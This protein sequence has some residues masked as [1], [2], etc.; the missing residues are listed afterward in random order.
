MANSKTLD[1][2]P[3]YLKTSANKR[4]LGATLDQ[5]MSEPRLKKFNG[6]IGRQFSPV[7]RRDDKYVIENTS[8]RQNYQLEPSIVISDDRGMAEFYANYTDILQQINFNGG[9]TN[10]H[11]RLFANQ[12]YSYNGHFDLDKLVNFTQYYWLP[13][14]P[15]VVEVGL[16]YVPLEKD[17][18]V[19]V[20]NKNN[21]YLFDTDPNKNPEIIL[22]RGGSYSFAVGHSGSKFYIQTELGSG[23]SVNNPNISTREIF[24]VVNNGVNTGTVV[25]N[26]PLSSDQ[27]SFKNMPVGFNADLATTLSYN[28]LANRLLSDVLGDYESIDGYVGDLNNKYIIFLDPENTGG[29]W[30]SI[31]ALDENDNPLP[32]YPSQTISLTNRANVFQIKLIELTT[33][34]LVTLINV[35]NTITDTRIFVNNGE[36]YGGLQWYRSGNSLVEYPIITAD[37]DILFYQN[38]SNPNL[39]GRIRL[40]DLETTVIDIESEILGKTE[41]TSPNGIKF[42]NGLKIGF[43]NSVTPSSYA[44]NEYYIEG[45]GK[46][47]R[48]IK[49]EDLIADW[50]SSTAY[51][52]DDLFLYDKIAYKVTTDF[53]SGTTFDE[54]GTS[55]G[56]NYEF[57]DNI[58][59]ITINR[60]SR[61]K[62]LWSRTNRWFHQRTI[63]S[64][65]NY[66]KV[67]M[68][69]NQSYR[70]KRPIIEFE[71]DLQ[72]FNF[73]R[74][75]I[76]QVDFYDN[77]YTDAFGTETIITFAGSTD[78]TTNPLTT[79]VFQDVTLTSGMKII[80]GADTD[81]DVKKTIYEI[82]IVE[83]DGNDTIILTPYAVV[84]E[85]QNV[86]VTNGFYANKYYHYQNNQWFQSQIKSTIQQKP[87]FD[88]FDIEGLSLSEWQFSN[89]V[90]TSLFSYKVGTGTDD[91]V[92]GFPLSYR[93]LGNVGDIE[94]TNNFEVDRFNY[95]IDNLLTTSDVSVGFLGKNISR[96]EQQKINVWS[97]SVDKTQQYQLFSEIGDGIKDS[98]TYNLIV[99]TSGVNTPVKVY[100]DNELENF[101]NIVITIADNKT[102]IVLDRVPEADS[103]IDIL[104][105][106]DQTDNSG[107]YQIPSNLENNALNDDFSELTLGQIRSHVKEVFSSLQD[108]VGVE[109]GN[110][111]SKDLD[112]SQISGTILQHSSPMIYG[113]LFLTHQKAN[114]IQGVQYAQKEYNKFKNR[115]LER[116]KSVNFY[117]Q[118]K[119]AE[120]VDEILKQLVLARATDSPWYYS[121]MVPYGDNRTTYS[122]T[123]LDVDIEY[124]QIESI[125]SESAASNRAVLVYLNSE[126]LIK[127]KDY[128]VSQTLPAIKLLPE[129]SRSLN[130]II[131]IV[132]YTNTDGNFVPETPT[133]L[134]LYPKFEP[135]IYL[136]DRFSEPISVI[137]GHDGSITPAFNDYRDLFLLELEK[138]IFNNLKTQYDIENRS[139]MW[140]ILPGKFR[141]S[142]FT[143]NEFDLIISSNFLKW[144]G[145]NQLD[146]ITNQFYDSNNSKTWNFKKSTSVLDNEVLPGNWR[147]IY[148][149]FYDTD[150]PHSHPWEMLGF[151]EKP[152]WWDEEYGAAPYTKGNSIL[153][154]DLE[155]GY[156]RQGTRIGIDSRFSRPGLS[157][158]IPVD[159][160][161]DLKTPDTF[162]IKNFNG[163]NTASSWAVGD[164]GPVESA[165]RMSSDYPYAMQIALAL[166]SPAEYFGLGIDNN[167]YLYFSELN[168]MLYSGTKDRIKPSRIVVHGSTVDGQIQRSAS[169]L[170]WIVDYLNGQGISGYA[171]VRR[172]LDQIDIRLSYKLSGFTDKNLLKIY[173]EQTS[174]GSTNDSILVPAENYQLLLHK[175]TPVRRAVYSAVIIK[176]T[177]T[178]YSVEG[179]D[180]HNP[181][182]TIVPSRSNNNYSVIKGIEKSAKI[183]KDYQL[184]YLTIPYG[185]E[186]QNRQQVVDFLISYQRYLN[187]LGFKF[188]EFNDELKKAQDWNLSSQEFLVWSEQGWG[189]NSILVLS[190]AIGK[191]YLEDSSAVVDEINGIWGGSRL[192]DQNF[193][194]I[195]G[196]EFETVRDSDSFVVET[197]QNKIIG[198]ADLSLVQYEH[199]LLLDNQTVFSDIIYDPNVGGRQFRL[200][201]V[202]SKTADWA[203]RLFAPGFI[204]TNG[205]IPNWQA[206][207]DYQKGDLVSFKNRIYS[208]IDFIPAKDL[209][210][211]ADWSLNTTATTTPT[212]FLNFSAD[213]KKFVSIYDV[214]SDYYDVNLELYS[215]SLIGFRN[216]SYL[217][218]FSLEPKTQ[219]KFYQGFIKQKGTRNAVN[220]LTNAQF[221]KLGGDIDFYE[222]WAVRV[223]SFGAVS[224]KKITEVIINEQL[225]DSNPFGVEILSSNETG[226]GDMFRSYSVA[227]LYSKETDFSGNLFNYRNN[228]DGIYDQDIV[229]AGPVRP[230][231]ADYAIFN[232][233]DL[234]NQPSSLVSNIDTGYK[235]W[236]AK[237]FSSQWNI[238][239]TVNTD[240]LLTTI[241]YGVDNTAE[242]VFYN[243][244]D[245]SEEEIII[246]KGFDDI[247]DGVYQVLSVDSLYSVTVIT[248]GTRTAYLESAVTVESSGIIFKLESMKL[249][250]LTDVGD[251]SNWMDGDLVYVTYP[252]NSNVYEKSS[253]WQWDSTFN[254]TITDSNWG[255]I[256]KLSPNERM[257][258]IGVPKSSPIVEYYNI[259]STP[260]RLTIA[261][262][263]S[264]STYFGHSV[265]LTNNRMFISSYGYSSNRGYIAVYKLVGQAYYLDQILL[266][267]NA[268]TGK[269]GYSMSVSE[270][271]RWLYAGVPG[272]NKVRRF[273]RYEVPRELFT[274]STT[275]PTV[276]YSLNWTVDPLSSQAIRVYETSSEQWLAEGIDY[277]ITGTNDSITFTVPA[278]TEYTIFKDSHYV[279]AGEITEPSPSAGDEFG[280]DIKCST[281][282]RQLIVGA[283]GRNSDSGKIFIYDRTVEA[284]TSLQGSTVFDCERSLQL[285]GSQPL[286]DVRVNGLLKEYLVDYVRTD[287][288]T[289]TFTYTLN[290]GDIVEIENNQFN[291]IQEFISELD[292]ANSRFGSRVNLCSY[293]CSVY[294]SQPEYQTPT[295]KKGVVSR[296]VN[297]SRIEGSITGGI[298]SSPSSCVTIGHSIRINDFE[299][300]FTG[301]SLTSVID[302]IEN[303]SIPGISVS[304]SNGKITISADS[305]LANNTLRI[306]PGLGTGLE[307]LE[308]TIFEF[309]QNIFKPGDSDQDYGYSIELSPDAERFYV[310]GGNT[311]IIYR[312]TWS[313]ET[314]WDSNST[315]FFDEIDQAGTI[316]EYDLLTDPDDTTIIAYVQSL[317]PETLIDDPDFNKVMAIGNNS[318]IMLSKKDAVVG[319]ID[320]FKNPSGKKGWS[321][322]RSQGQIVDLNS[323]D[324]FYLYNKR[325]NSLVT[326]LD[327][328]DPARGKVL[329][330]ADQF[331]D[332]KSSFDPAV[333][334][335]INST[336]SDSDYFWSSYQIGK[337]WWN[338]DKIRYIDYQQSNREYRLRNWGK[339]FE[340]SQ[341]EICEWVESPVLPSQYRSRGLSGIPLFEDDSRYSQITQVDTQSGLLKTKYYFWVTDKITAITNK[342]ISISSIK[343][344]IQDP[345]QQD[346]PYVAVLDD[347][348][349]AIFNCNQYFS[350]NDIVLK[351]TSRGL[352]K[353]LPVHHEWQIIREK[354][355]ETIPEFLVT[356]LV[357][358]LLGNSVVGNE[359]RE[360]PDTTL[361]DNMRYGIS[362]R[363]RQ[364]M[365]VDRLAASKIFVNYINRELQ[366][367]IIVGSKDITNLYQKDPEP[368]LGYTLEFDSYEELISIDLTSLDNG[369]VVLVHS[370]SEYMGN[371]ALYQIDDGEL[372]AIQ[373]QQYNLDDYWA[374][375]DWYADEFNQKTIPNYI[376]NTFSELAG[377]NVQEGEI[378]RIN[379]IGDGNWGIYQKSG[380]SYDPKGIGNGTIQI[381]SL[382][383]DPTSAGIGLDILS[384]DSIRF[385]Y[386]PTIAFRTMIETLRNDIL[387][388]D[389]KYIFVGSIFA[390]FEYIFYEQ[391][392]PDWLFKTSFISVNHNLRRLD[393]YPSYVRDNQDYYR[394]YIEEVKPYRTKIREY[395]L[396]YE[397]DDIAPLSLSDFDLPAYYDPELGR[398]RSIDTETDT[399]LLEQQPYSLWNQN[400]SFYIEN[401]EII[402]GGGDYFKEPTL[403]VNGGNGKA[404]LRATVEGG[405]ITG[406]TIVNGGG[407]FMEVPTITVVPADFGNSAQLIARLTNKTVRSIATTIKFDRIA[408]TGQ[409]QNWQ[410]NTSYVNNDIFVHENKFYLTYN[411]FTSGATFTTAPTTT[412]LTALT[413]ESNPAYIDVVSI[414]GFESTGGYFI[415]DDEIFQYDY[416][417]LAF[418]RFE[419]VT[420]AKLDSTAA[421]HSIGSTVKRFN[422]KEIGIAELRSAMERAYYY[423]Q[424]GTGMTPNDVKQLFS[425]VDYSGVRVQGTGEFAGEQVTVY[426][427]EYEGAPQPELENIDVFYRSSFLDTS[428]G[429]RAED[430]NVHGGKFVDTFNSHAPEEL[431]P[432]RIYDTLEIRVFTE[433]SGNFIGFRVFHTMN[434]NTTDS[435]LNPQPT[436]QLAESL[437]NSATSVKVITYENSAV[438]LPFSGPQATYNPTIVINGETIQY[439]NYNPGSG[440]ISGMIRGAGAVN[441]PSGSFVT[442]LDNLKDYRFYYRISGDHTTTLAEPLNYYD[443]EIKL[444]DS[445]NFIQPSSTDNIPGIV[446]INGEK[447]VYWTINYVTHT[448]GQLTRGVSGT[449]IPEIH[450]SGSLISDA[451]Q[452]QVIDN[453]DSVVWSQTGTKLFDSI[454]TQAGFLKTKYSYDPSN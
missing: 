161:G 388:D 364:T 144:V 379:N 57:Y 89:F 30:T 222:E 394:S 32:G 163:N 337:V 201:L 365:F 67:P 361:S 99:S 74:E 227:D 183:Y 198:L 25:F 434:C 411:D 154:T 298:I 341:V 384:F 202:G 321:L 118:T 178:G 375:S 392:Q 26:V 7:S 445:T 258:A 404:R 174:P 213:A 87:L 316:Y 162:L 113:G 101:D 172:L 165:W 20:N 243:R 60:G 325:T 393:Q 39:S 242:F 27:D 228:Q 407:D 54:P 33:D 51:S 377:Y 195:K 431:I 53:T 218:D 385:D 155:N 211:F 28:Q 257:L 443:T 327:H 239:Q 329:G 117:D 217:D 68:I 65:A 77:T 97:S 194:S 166:T 50:E 301:Q 62:N 72:L 306:L 88:V 320:I 214:D 21:G 11:S 354:N 308:L 139:V 340:G 251:K 232:F 399:E 106:S 372:T 192:L 285:S 244:H 137:Q 348:S 181:Y 369:T 438:M 334:N 159:E 15:D 355:D 452:Q 176:K 185:Y 318:A 444:T 205:S 234:I 84:E 408:Y 333:Y 378:V 128:E 441:H 405:I 330:V 153:W 446:F 200:K 417:T 448:L 269:F 352:S 280:Y 150:R 24:G 351:I 299:I 236:T 268:S 350:S 8:D 130:D 428:L 96:T 424:P 224:N 2:L 114:F 253:P 102:T 370:S 119:V 317:I 49:V 288:D 345:V 260:Y 125:I 70:A 1:F 98:F 90:G 307:D 121:D 220:A 395:L 262:P 322:V 454:T 271:Q 79:L 142:K 167:R 241:N 156:I 157:R 158:I 170:N 294:V 436:V 136:D 414:S 359:L 184:V 120:H 347:R 143:K 250:R 37:Q 212:L 13:N 66:N 272:D 296:Y 134:G 442:V 76:T 423:Y 439:T 284:F 229:T 245:L 238:Y 397:G 278:T 215:H 447:I 314:T 10:A 426:D 124:Y 276:T 56:I 420:R 396:R 323:I 41:Y 186:F 376:I 223:G 29:N 208:A 61:D 5:L 415:I 145:S 256:A 429:T 81:N 403:I 132:E 419:G 69:L 315:N 412:L 38:D 390:M 386:N 293:N 382:I 226:S 47:I 295:Y 389:L 190:P 22:R 216:R 368:T 266:G 435:N 9:I 91:S 332:F 281:D 247:L 43:D 131:T 52:V 357:D 231:E 63:L 171:E 122:Y 82:S 23:V 261:P 304:Q 75:F 339:L 373:V 188:D 450:A 123:V 291:L 402:N 177:R 398:Y 383:Y 129:L 274:L 400:H 358:S 353:D 35:H 366:K 409:I 140:N 406:V 270:D 80:F 233:R 86:E 55:K 249:D 221:N 73:G 127:N 207:K 147:G 46:S 94:F 103:K 146:Y 235:I 141:V 286:F 12:N 36:N 151:S 225:R 112:Y 326:Y 164:M 367:N 248:G 290:G 319:K 42:E 6:Y 401:V 289:I 422:Y 95:Q 14:G 336:T 115:F 40:V 449:G 437:S 275:A 421:A 283:P 168:Q 197:F 45:V 263:L 313:D 349:L 209:F 199:V 381:N 309:S 246:V 273:K 138:R 206:G 16:D 240:N 279:Y 59:Y 292:Q 107:F 149:Y 189:E 391:K 427:I 430:I 135:K 338:L 259:A 160:Y 265:E 300:F 210:D 187:S 416:I 297:R 453:A 3:E 105:Y 410:A 255:R 78:L 254:T 175:S 302:D 180:Y 287:S 182:F 58:D 83:L 169:W 92:L 425:G 418:N 346:I 328:I 230:D 100:I 344:I 196:S 371:W 203:G 380:L 148:R 374:F 303:A 311:T 310:S 93:N 362:I 451:S 44:N 116:A 331:L 413:D 18:V 179:Y 191:L 85:Y 440:I 34:Y 133:K 71:S 108:L 305:V 343:N 152:S 324:N 363:P 277:T 17:F 342:S 126:Q 335:K 360:V 64:S 48:L 264:G 219:V 433:D 282:G 193:V 4:F 110:N 432:G 31:A 356:K 173:A 267:G 237:D 204:Y 312:P 111:N 104:I 109:L 387:I 252:N 19:T